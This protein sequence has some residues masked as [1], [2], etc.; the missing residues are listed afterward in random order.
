MKPSLLLIV[1]L[2][3]LGCATRGPQH[4]VSVGNAHPRGSIRDVRVEV[5]GR[6][7]REFA[8]IGGNKTAALRPRRGAA[9]QEITVSWTTPDGTARRET[10][11]TGLEPGEHFQG[12]MVVEINESQQA[13][14]WKITT[15]DDDDS[16][17]PWAT[18]ESWEGTVGIPGMSER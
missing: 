1:F 11:R 5:D 16:I 2:S 10:V 18:P 9:P 7:D 4:Q 8:A 12:N 6:L 15:T 13:R 3:L 14:L 17:L